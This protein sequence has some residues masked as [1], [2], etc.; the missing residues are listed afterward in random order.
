MHCQLNVFTP[1]RSIVLYFPCAI[2]IT[3]LGVYV[4]YFWRENNYFF[5]SH[6]RLNTAS[7]QIHGFKPI[8]KGRKSTTLWQYIFLPYNNPRHSFVCFS[9][10][11]SA[12]WWRTTISTTTWKKMAV[13]D[14]ATGRTVKVWASAVAWAATWDGMDAATEWGKNWRSKKAVW[15]A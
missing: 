6:V 9:R 11:R 4:R 15:P 13:S 8:H 10:W 5:F 1:F 14:I 3:I 2:N 7:Y 12:T